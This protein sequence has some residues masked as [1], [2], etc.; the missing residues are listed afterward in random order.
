LDH[1]PPLEIGVF[2]IATLLA[3]FSRGDEAMQF[4]QSHLGFSP[5][6]G[7]GSMEVLFL[8]VA[9]MIMVALWLHFT[10][11]AAGA[12]SAVNVSVRPHDDKPNASSHE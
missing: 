8:V 1:S 2:P 6:R 10:S 3:K 9:L 7:D 11:R 4:I 12:S 5:D